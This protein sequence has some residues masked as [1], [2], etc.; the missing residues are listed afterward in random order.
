MIILRI[1][2]GVFKKISAPLSIQYDP[3]KKNRSFMRQVKNQLIGG[4][5][6]KERNPKTP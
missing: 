2:S 1:L 4:T 3:Y 5:S 6:N